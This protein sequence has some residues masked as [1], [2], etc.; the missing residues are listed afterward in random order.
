MFS[1]I[2]MVCVQRKQLSVG[3]NTSGWWQGSAGSRGQAIFFSKRP[4]EALP[5]Q[6]LGG[7]GACRPRKRFPTSVL[8]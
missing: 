3:G 6:A 4:R 2:E 8:G 7:G 1:L 5:R